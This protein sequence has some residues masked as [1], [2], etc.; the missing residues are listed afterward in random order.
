MEQQPNS[1]SQYEI[2][3]IVLVEDNKHDVLA[4]QRVLQ[5]SPKR[6]RITVHSR[7]ETLLSVLTAQADWSPN[8]D[9]IVCDQ[10]LPG[11]SGLE[12]YKT[13][14]THRVRIPFIL[15]TGSG[16]E[17]LAVE[18]LKMGVSD[19]VMKDQEG[20]YLRLLP[21]VLPQVI[22]REKETLRRKEVERMNSRRGQMLAS[23]VEVQK[24]LLS[25][26]I[27]TD[28][29]SAYQKVL[30][31]LSDL[32]QADRMYIFENHYQEQGALHL[33]L[34]AEWHLSTLQSMHAQMGT[35]VIPYTHLLPP[36]SEVILS[37][38]NVL[39][40]QEWL[41][42]ERRQVQRSQ[43]TG[44]ESHA[45]RL[46]EA[47]LYL[48]LRAQEKFLGIFAVEKKSFAGP[49]DE[50]E[51][52]L[53]RG[54]A[55]A[56]SQWREQYHSEQQL[57]AYAEEMAQ[58][59]QELDAFAHMVAHDLKNPLAVLTTTS[60]VL[61]DMQA[62]LSQQET[63]ELIDLI[64]EYTEKA[65]N[66][67]NELL[68]LSSTRREDVEV[69]PVSMGA[70]VNHAIEQ[71]QHLIDETGAEIVQPSQW[72]LVMGHAPWLEA[73]WVNYISNGLKYGGSPPRLELGAMRKGK[74]SV[75]FW[76]EDNGNGI[77]PDEQA[78]LFTPFTR[79]AQYKAQGNGLG[80]SIVNR[81]I[82]KLGGETGVESTG[83]PGA[84]SRFFF[85]LPAAH[86]K[87]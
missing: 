77:Q 58:Q 4:M 82:D 13:L 51:V 11:I 26:D 49:M 66:I 61:T 10:N 76:I 31:L 38:G 56:I 19:Y 12:L 45:A 60:D 62:D 17:E 57:R 69:E 52:D 6:Y 33:S 41:E 81:V 5:K 7:A 3:D 87:I 72:P 73:V 20:R 46:H 63:Q 16:A 47:T 9:V 43:L 68:L 67:V 8:I 2:L 22:A 74:D 35:K 78:K 85:T 65:I 30:L 24:T 59:N 55:A 37:A 71:L 14:Q 40:N 54:I 53:L 34:K 32:L 42:K 1:P 48:P 83:E 23:L 84:G 15:L 28:L 80:L 44:K 70:V 39:S 75:C 29:E 64:Q 86:L 79:L 18:A 27:R 21:T 50:A 25:F 36:W